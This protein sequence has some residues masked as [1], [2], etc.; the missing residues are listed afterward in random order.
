MVAYPVE[1]IQNYFMSEINSSKLKWAMDDLFDIQQNT[2]QGGAFISEEILHRTREAT[3]VIVNAI[4]CGELV[5]SR[6]MNTSQ[7]LM[8]QILISKQETIVLKERLALREKTLSEIDD[9]LSEISGGL[10]DA[11]EILGNIHQIG[12]GTILD[13]AIE[14]VEGAK[15]KTESLISDVEPD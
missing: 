6:E 5:L 8:D 9:K 7:E 4:Y 15:D 10:T 1:L 2:P 14:L 11:L 3:K 13:N 12:N